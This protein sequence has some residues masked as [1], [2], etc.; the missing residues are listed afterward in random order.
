MKR[1]E[2]LVTCSAAEPRVGQ[3]VVS[4]F[5]DGLIET[6]ELII[7]YHLHVTPQLKMMACLRS[8]LLI[9]G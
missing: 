2:R 3:A 5:Y 7:V 8:R 9:K 4:P 1:T 6:N